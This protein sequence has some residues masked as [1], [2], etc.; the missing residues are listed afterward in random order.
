MATVEQQATA[1]PAKA[2]PAP[3]VV[4]RTPATAGPINPPSWKMVEFTLIA[5]RR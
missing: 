2:Q 3:T 4:S 1:F 5:F